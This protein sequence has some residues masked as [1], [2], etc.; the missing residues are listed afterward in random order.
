MVSEFVYLFVWSHLCF[1][2]SCAL[3]FIAIRPRHHNILGP[4]Y[5]A[6]TIQS[7]IR[8][9]TSEFLASPLHDPITLLEPLLDMEWEAR[10]SHQKTVHCSYHFTKSLQHLVTQDTFHHI[11]ECVLPGIE[12]GRKFMNDH[13]HWWLIVS[14]EWSLRIPHVQRILT[15]LKY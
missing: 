1:W 14:I 2:E 3:L 4:I 11:L 13:R 12:R 7:R 9:H 15:S 5:I 6:I 10:S 8:M